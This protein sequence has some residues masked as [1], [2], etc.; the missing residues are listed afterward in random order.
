[1]KIKNPK[2]HPGMGFRNPKRDGYEVGAKVN[3]CD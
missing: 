3:V 2:N 1:L